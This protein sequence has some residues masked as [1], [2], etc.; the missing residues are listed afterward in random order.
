M[1]R[2]C[3]CHINWQFS[4]RFILQGQLKMVHPCGSTANTKTWN[5]LRPPTTT[6]RN[7]QFFVLSGV[8][9]IIY[10][11]E[12]IISRY[13]LRQPKSGTLNFLLI[14]NNFWKYLYYNLY[15]HKSFYRSFW[16]F[17]TFLLID[18]VY[19]NQSQWTSQAVITCTETWRDDRNPGISWNSKDV[20]KPFGNAAKGSLR[21]IKLHTPSLCSALKLWTPTLL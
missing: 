11:Q 7:F 8:K 21:R 10:R 2:S 15:Y 20:P 18:E 3:C 12:I 9:E 4:G 6:S 5:D 14:C 16:D 17:L 19:L 1:H 13:R